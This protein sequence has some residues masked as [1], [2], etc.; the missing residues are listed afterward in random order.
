MR[1]GNPIPWGDIPA[2][3]FLPIMAGEVV[4]PNNTMESVME[5]IQN[6]IDMSTS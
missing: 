2:R 4:L 1:N 5:I 3:P 6:Y